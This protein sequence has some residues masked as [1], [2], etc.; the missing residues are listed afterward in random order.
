MIDNKDFVQLS[1]YFFDVCEMLKTAIQ[2]KN[3]D[4]LNEPVRTA[5]KDLER[6]VNQPSSSCLPTTETI[7]E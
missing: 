6:C 7:L 1:E 3:M 2:G 4:D 5:L